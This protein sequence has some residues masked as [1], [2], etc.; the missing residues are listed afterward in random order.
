MSKVISLHTMAEKTRKKQVGLSGLL[1]SCLL[2]AVVL[3]LHHASCVSA[4]ASNSPLVHLSRGRIQDHLHFGAVPSKA[5]HAFS[6]R[7]VVSRPHTRHTVSTKME[8]FGSTAAMIGVSVASFY[9]ASPLLAGFLTCGVKA[10]MADSMAQ[11]R[12]VCTTQFSIR[13]NLA[14]VIYSGTVLGLCAE[15]MYN[16]LFP[17]IFGVERTWPTIIMKTLFDGFVNAPLLWLPPAYLV[18]G[19]L[20]KYPMGKALRKYRKDVRENGLLK[21]Y[22]SL[23]LPVSFLNFSVVPPH[24]RVAFVA[25]VSFFWMILLSVVANNNQDPESC[26]LEQEP[27]FLAPRAL[28]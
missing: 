27:S 14:M 26:P 4:F 6:Q 8:A 11:W 19:L 12:D 15:I 22:W 24:F 17:L 5:E 25:L 7:K 1:R 3:V 2:A 20:Y 10:G 13:R 23:W 21:K 28:D 9:K 16:R 18:Q